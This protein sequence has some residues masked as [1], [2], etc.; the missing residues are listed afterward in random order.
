M[1]NPAAD[2]DFQSGPWTGF[3]QV[4]G[5]KV[6]QDLELTFGDG[7]LRGG[8]WD[9]RGEFVVRGSYDLDSREVRLT[10]KYDDH[11]VSC[12]GFLDGKGIWGTWESGVQHGA[13][14]HIWPLQAAQ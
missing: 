2:A 4:D 5:Q 6:P 1:S 11:K 3:F 14:F 12:R 9:A 13:G 8:G 10:K 7:V